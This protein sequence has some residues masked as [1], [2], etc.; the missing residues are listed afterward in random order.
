[1]KPAPPV[2]RIVLLIM[3]FL[4][5]ADVGH[6]PRRSR[7]V[8]ERRPGIFFLMLFYIEEPFL[9]RSVPANHKGKRT[10]AKIPIAP[11]ELQKT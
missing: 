4:L 9:A 8:A 2:M 5:Q 6:V 10:P 11:S 7:P 3:S 1:M